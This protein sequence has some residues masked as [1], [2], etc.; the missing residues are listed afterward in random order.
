M[1]TA[2]RTRMVF[3]RSGIPDRVPVHSW[4][5]LPLIRELK[6]KNKKM[7]EMLEWWIDDRWAVSSRCSRSWA[8]T[9]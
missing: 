5:G 7:I 1:K 8:W 4:L 2:E 6:P 3:T 9:R